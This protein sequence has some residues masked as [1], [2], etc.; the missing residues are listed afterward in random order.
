VSKRICSSV[1]DVTSLS[2]SLPDRGT[3]ASTTTSYGINSSGV[4]K[5]RLLGITVTVSFNFRNAAM[6]GPWRPG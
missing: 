4:A 2:P 5:S 3:S 1:N 6:S